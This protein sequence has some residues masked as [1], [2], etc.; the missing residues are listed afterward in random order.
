MADECNDDVCLD[1]TPL[2]VRSAIAH[3]AV[4]ETP[5]INDV[6]ASNYDAIFDDA[7]VDNFDHP[8]N[9]NFDAAAY[10]RGNYDAG[11]YIAGNCNASIFTAANVPGNID[12]SADLPGH[13]NPGN[14]YAATNVPGNINAA[15]DHS[16]NNNAAA[17]DNASNLP[18]NDEANINVS[19]DNNVSTKYD[20]AAVLF[21]FLKIHGGKNEGEML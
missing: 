10:L 18:G 4:G 15:A 7:A 19:T 9:F 17:I 13:R 2:G 14:I 6:C 3:S 12:A 11:S 8:G 5:V 21:S 16:S 1:S 20:A